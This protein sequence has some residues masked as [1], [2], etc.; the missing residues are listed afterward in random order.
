MSDLTKLFASKKKGDIVLVVGS[1]GVDGAKPKPKTPAKA[2]VATP[3][4]VGKKRG[5][6]EMEGEEVEKDF[7]E[8]DA[9]QRR[10]KRPRV[11][12]TKVAT[13]LLS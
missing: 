1:K 2:K 4:V 10:A 12:S 5:R 7:E 3:K 11:P 13:V 9:E 6:E 8:A